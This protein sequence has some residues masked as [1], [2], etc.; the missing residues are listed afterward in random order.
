MDVSKI[1]ALKQD[2]ASHNNGVKPAAK[3]Q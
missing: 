2:A 3:K 1:N